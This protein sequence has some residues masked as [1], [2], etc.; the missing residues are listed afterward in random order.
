[1]DTIEEYQAYNWLYDQ[2]NPVPMAMESLLVQLYD[3][4]IIKVDEDY[5]A[6]LIKERGDAFT[7]D[8][9]VAALVIAAYTSGHL[10]GGAND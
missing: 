5:V 2:T 10:K 8:R 1:M 3:A 4:K 9:E 6:T 7:S